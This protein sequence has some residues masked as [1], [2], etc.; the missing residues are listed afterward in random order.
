MSKCSDEYRSARTNRGSVEDRASC[1]IS[2]A[3]ATARRLSAIA[4]ESED[5]MKTAAAAKAVSF[6]FLSLSLL[7]A[8]SLSG[9]VRLSPPAELRLQSMFPLIYS[10]VDQLQV[11]QTPGV[12]IF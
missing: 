2:V 3:D 8:L 4:P 7:F 12:Q 10:T 6:D 1:R 9:T 5:A 11:G